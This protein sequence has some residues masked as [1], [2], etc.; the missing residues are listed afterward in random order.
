MEPLRRD[1]R[2]GP[3]PVINRLQ[4]QLLEYFAALERVF[5]Y[6]RSEAA[7]LLLTKHRTQDG[8]RRTGQTRLH[9]WLKKHGPRSIVEPLLGR[10]RPSPARAGALQELAAYVQRGP[11]KA[12]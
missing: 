11:A 8:I 6:S 5:D 10:M 7:L 2:S 1:R 12:A 4:A 3:G 9:A